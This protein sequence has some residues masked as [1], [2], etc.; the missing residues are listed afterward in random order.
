VSRFTRI[1]NQ[2]DAGLWRERRPL[3]QRVDIELTERCNNACRHC[4]IN[5]PAGDARARRTELTTEELTAFLSE[6]AGL[7]ALTVRFTGGEPLL[8]ED[9]PEVYM[10]ARRAGLQVLL[11]TN[12]CLI[13]PV[14]A[15]LL[16]RTPP[17]A[18]IQVSVYGMSAG[19]YGAVS[20]VHG[21]FA[22]F[23]RGLDLLL[24]RGLP[25][26]L[27]GTALPQTRDEAEQLEA[28]ADGLGLR[29]K[30]GWVALL[31]LR[32]RR[33]DQAKNGLIESLRLDAAEVVR[34]LSARR[35]EYLEDL[36]D[37]CRRFMAPPGEALFD[38][39]A[40][41][42]ISLGAHGELHPC[43]A[44]HAPETAYD[45]RCG[46]LGEA[47]EVFFPEVRARR[48]ADPEYLR[49]CARCFLSGLCEQCPAWSWMEHGTLD[50]PVEY[51]CDVAHAQARALGL[52][53]AGERS[54]EIQDWAERKERL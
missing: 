27:T 17:R 22:R 42:A 53:R 11:T 38:C 21:A 1:M 18:P 9:F 43:L 8:R 19:S 44:L 20:N 26:A 2:R 13:T 30:P 40:G 52:L 29:E 46:T 41:R 31:Y 32:A 23:R 6:A 25:V 34:F 54:W 47:M 12:A 24:E 45:W 49:R 16:A 5:Q 35:D 36:K 39:G 33:D 4:Y 10:S 50:K 28:W 14:L 3:L 48:A 15:D 37:F 7:G 51:L